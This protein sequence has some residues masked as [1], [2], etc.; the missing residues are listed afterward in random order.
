MTELEAY[1]VLGWNPDGPTPGL[2]FVLPPADSENRN[3]WIAYGC[4][5]CGYHGLSV[6]EAF[7]PNCISCG[8][9]VEI[10]EGPM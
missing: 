3:D 10:A 8:K 9:P 5:D 4:P 1:K 2:P 7:S 6:P